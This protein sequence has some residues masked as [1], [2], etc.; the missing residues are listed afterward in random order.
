VVDATHI[1]VGYG[2]AVMLNERRVLLGS[3]RYM[4]LNQVPL[5]PEIQQLAQKQQAGGHSLVYLA[6]DGVLQ[7]MLELQPTLRPE[8]QSI[9]NA[10]HARGLQLVMITGDQE[11]PARAMA[12]T[13][14]IDR[15]F[16]NVLPEQKAELVKELQAQG[17]KVMFVGDGINDS[18]ALK[19]AHVS[20]SIAGAT[21]VATDT[22]QI[23]LMDGT[24]A[25]LDTLFDLSAR[26]ESD[27]R[28]QFILGVYI[29]AGYIAGVLLWGWGMVSSYVIGYIVFLT[30]TGLAFRPI[31][32]Q[33]RLAS[34]LQPALTVATGEQAP[35]G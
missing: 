3:Q 2:L 25:Q 12:N 19:Q 11:A 31:W 27:L 24:L 22:A 35:T 26:Y 29:P 8:A 10:L 17:R 13:L 28:K 34:K 20:V 32:R 33:E 15:V 16:A 1:E 6:V 7:G 4:T 18:I 5:T 23:V 21:T 9:V 14:G 30:A